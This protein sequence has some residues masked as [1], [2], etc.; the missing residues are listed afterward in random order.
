M[1][2]VNGHVAWVT[3][4]VVLHCH[5][6]PGFIKIAEFQQKKCQAMKRQ[7]FHLFPKNPHARN[8][9]SLAV[10]AIDAK[11]RAGAPVLQPHDIWQ[12]WMASNDA[13]P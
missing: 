11:V 6:E 5:S 3:P 13:C 9:C 8:S 10:A 7:A 1:L 12:H 2:E 4:A